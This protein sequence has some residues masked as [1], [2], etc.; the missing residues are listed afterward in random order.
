MKI[1]E[2]ID[3]ICEKEP[4]YSS[5]V[6]ELH[7]IEDKNCPTMGT[8]GQN[9]YYNPEF[10][11][12]LTNQEICG[13]VLHETLHCVFRHIWRKDKRH[14]LLWNIAADY[15]INPTVVESYPIPKGAL[16]DMKYY[17]MSAE[18]IYDSFDD[19][20]KQDGE[21]E[22]GEEGEDD[23]EGKE[24]KS[25]GGGNGKPKKQKW[26]DHGKWENNKG[27]KQKKQSWVDKILGKAK[28]IKVNNRALEE[29]WKKLMKKKLLNNYGKL[30][31]SLKR[32]ISKSYYIPVL[33]WT[34]LVSN[35]LSEDTNDYTF[36]Q[37]DRRF[38]DSDFFFPGLASVDRLKDVIFAYD[39]SGSIND[40]DLH[41][42]YMETIS[43]F[44]NFSSL[45]GWV[46]ICD[47]Y[48][49]SF[50]EINPQTTYNQFDFQGGGGTSFQPVFNKIKEQGLKPKA[51]FYFTDTEGDYPQE[52]PE[53]PVFWLVRS[54]VG[55]NYPIKVPFGTV[56][57][58][59]A[60][61][62]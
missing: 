29:K 13:V 25:G 42:F 50:K 26:G 43:L 55:D 5:L 17:G 30:P 31:D 15:A 10:M 53:Y 20:D 22:D 56:V 51:V 37:P 45:Q 12:T 58:F 23:K 24:G 57:K 48:L 2:A 35:L 62:I 3:A 19:K 4:L 9:L 1:Q 44:D 60:K 34:S 47:S 33:D 16:L 32:I 59:L 36:S 6:R 21:G 11:K 40:D 49:H 46:A 39:T 14:H 8:D 18:E 7:P 38:M 61:S 52:A 27:K 28:E 41:A 54:Q